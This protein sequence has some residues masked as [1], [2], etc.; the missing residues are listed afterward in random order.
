MFFFRRALELLPKIVEKLPGL[1]HLTIARI[2]G[3]MSQKYVYLNRPFVKYV[4]KSKSLYKTKQNK[5]EK[6]KQAT[7]SQFLIL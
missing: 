2:S 4:N 6:K 3:A 5:K 1:F 7:N